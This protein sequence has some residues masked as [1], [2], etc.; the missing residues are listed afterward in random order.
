M[1]ESNFDKFATAKQKLADLHAAHPDCP[2]ADALHDALFAT[3]K[4]HRHMFTDEQYAV[5]ATP[6]GGGTPKES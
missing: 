5:L 1:R 3:L 6:L 2:E 4:A